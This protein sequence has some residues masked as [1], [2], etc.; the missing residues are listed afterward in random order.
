[1]HGW[2]HWRQLRGL[3]TPMDKQLA[4]LLHIGVDFG[5]SLVPFRQNFSWIRDLVYSG[6][7]WHDRGLFPGSQWMVQVKC[8]FQKLTFGF[9]ARTSRGSVPIDSFERTTTC[10][11]CIPSPRCAEHDLG[12]VFCCLYLRIF[13]SCACACSFFSAYA[14]MVASG[15]EDYTKEQDKR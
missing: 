9:T 2:I 6:V 12:V 15:R 10:G 14:L 8:M 7:L 3:K 5:S 11:P 13:F 4:S 1:M